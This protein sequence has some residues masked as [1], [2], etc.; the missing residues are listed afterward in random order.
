MSGFH[1]PSLTLEFSFLCP[2]PVGSS[3]CILS[4]HIFHVSLDFPFSSKQIIVMS[5]SW[6]SWLLCFRPW[7]F[8]FKMPFVACSTRPHIFAKKSLSK[9]SLPS[10]AYSD[11]ISGEKDSPFMY[12]YMYV[13]MYLILRERQTDVNL[14]FHLFMLSLVASPICPDQRLNLQ[15]W[16]IGMK[17]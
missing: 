11:H 17:P 10:L 1:S 13:C 8:T 9:S 5:L 15:P 3:I 12:V 4:K 2:G 14:L 6:V 7:H 16:Y